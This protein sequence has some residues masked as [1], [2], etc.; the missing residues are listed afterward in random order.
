MKTVKELKND[1]S[2]VWQVKT[3][4]SSYLIDLD[5]RRF[6]RNP[7]QGAG[8]DPSIEGRTIVVSDL[9]HVLPDSEWTPLWV[10]GLCEV[11]TPMMLHTRG[12]LQIRSTIVRSIERVYDNK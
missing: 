10:V 5:K 6:L 1:D 11:G 2:G 4:A 12:F 3:E 7:G 9:S 8:A